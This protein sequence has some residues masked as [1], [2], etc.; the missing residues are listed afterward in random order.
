MD[1]KIKW[2]KWIIPIFIISF[3]FVI[4]L[5]LVRNIRIALGCA[6]IFYAYSPGIYQAI[7]EYTEEERQAL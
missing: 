1:E 2:Y 6:L 7:K 3:Y 4:Y 5:F